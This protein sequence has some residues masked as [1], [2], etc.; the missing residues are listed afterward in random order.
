MAVGG[1]NGAVFDSDALPV[2][3]LVYSQPLKEQHERLSDI[4][5]E[6]FIVTPAPF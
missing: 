5:G 1:R 4:A 3:F 6:L 2:K